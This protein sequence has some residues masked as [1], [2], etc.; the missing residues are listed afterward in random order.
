MS[1]KAGARDF[2]N[3]TDASQRPLVL[4]LTGRSTDTRCLGEKYVQAFGRELHFLDAAEVSGKDYGETIDLLKKK[5]NKLGAVLLH[6]LHNLDG[7]QAEALHVVC[8][9]ESPLV[10]DA[11]VVLTSET[12]LNDIGD[13]WKNHVAEDKLPALL[14]RIGSRVVVVSSENNL[15]CAV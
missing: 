12:S 4:L 1:L 6:G 3:S 15:P 8:D 10:R 5:I 7:N 2:A 14:T 13:K 11:V 9:R